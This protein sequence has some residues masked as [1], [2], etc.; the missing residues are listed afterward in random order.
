MLG[1]A[2]M[3]GK[4]VAE[5][6][7]YVGCRTNAARKAKGRGISVYRA[8]ASGRWELIEV[9]PADDP[10]F[11]ATDSH[12]RWIYAI[13]GDGL[14]ISAYARGRNGCLELLN[15]RPTHGKNP[16]HVAISPDDKFA[17]VCNHVTDGE[18]V[19]NLATLPIQADGS[20][21]AVV[22]LRPVTGEIGVNR[23]EQPHAKPHHVQ[24][25]PDGRTLA[26]ADK[27]L[28]EVQFFSLEPSGVLTDLP[29]RTVRLPW[30]AGPRHLVFHPLL[31]RLYVLNEL[32]S[33]IVVIA[34]D[35]ADGVPLPFQRLSSQS[36][37][38]SL[39]HRA[40]E[41]GLSADGRTLYASNRGQDTLGVFRVD[42]ATGVLAPVG[43]SDSA[44][45]FPRHFSIAPSGDRMF[46]A[47]EFTDDVVAFSVGQD[48][49]LSAPER[50]ATTGTPTCILL[51]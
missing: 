45:R 17:V 33:T 7:A 26:M 31:P 28:D 4:I 21:G 50:V 10:S 6:I 43:W 46:V 23:K 19:A 34:L 44:G 36:D 41:I 2:R 32:D 11:L 38:Y 3:G 25:A 5:H 30:G 20:L 12:G 15:R 47:N 48:G 16:V 49:A 35:A 42:G 29:E 22:D 24:F 40:A 9:H 13:E 27:G 1:P 51:I 39:I 37:R 8:P 18:W 14:T